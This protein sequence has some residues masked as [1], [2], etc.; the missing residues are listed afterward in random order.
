MGFNTWPFLI[1]LL[2]VILIYWLLHRNI[3]RLNFIIFACF[4]F[5]TYHLPIN[6]II[7]IGFAFLMFAFGLLINFANLRQKKSW[8]SKILLILGIFLSL[9][10]LSLY[11][12]RFFIFN[13]LAEIG[14]SQAEKY[15]HVGEFS[16]YLVPIGISFFVFEVIHYL[17]EI[18][19]SNIV[20]PKL[21]EFFLFV[22]F[23]PT[24]TAGPIKRFNDFISQLKNISFPKRE[25]LFYSL[26]RVT[27]G[28]AK[29]ILIADFLME[30]T[31][32][33]FLHHD[34]FLPRQ[35]LL[36]IYLFSLIIYLDFSGYSD[37][38][39]GISRLLGFKIPENF[40]SPYTKSNISEFWTSWHISLTKWVKDYLFIP[41]GGSR[42]GF[43]RYLLNLFLVFAVVGLWHGASWNFVF[44]GIYHGLGNIVYQAYKRLTAN[45]VRLNKPNIVS[46]ICSIF[47]TFNFVSF[48]WV[49]FKM[50]LTE[51]IK[52]WEYILISPMGVVFLLTNILA[53]LGILFKPIINVKINS[54]IFLL[55]KYLLEKEIIFL[56]IKDWGKLFFFST[57]V[58]FLVLFFSDNA[59]PYIY[60]QF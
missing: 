30:F 50:N 26:K 48:G 3:K 56:K 58:Y 5:I 8:L 20:N 12:Y 39:I 23:F 31:N 6:I 36:A 45:N 22:F 7:Y 55:V 57:V 4:V 53:M 43:P 15:S 34:F 28:L 51:T 32:L 21:K 13:S 47:L 25:A 37:V 1:F 42:K 60:E 44:W 27:L 35:C 46:Q 17:I 24:M 18:Y 41:L 11:K 2:A 29:K 54:N 10:F 59:A 52:F 16:S 14:F 9:C 49:L 40:N 38:A 19:K 33:I